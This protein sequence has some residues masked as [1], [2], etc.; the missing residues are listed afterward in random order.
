MRSIVRV[1]ELPKDGQGVETPD[2]ALNLGEHRQ[3]MANNSTKI[4]GE[5]TELLGGRVAAKTARR[6]E[7][8]AANRTQAADVVVDA[9]GTA[10]DL[11]PE[12]RRTFIE[13]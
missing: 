4:G 8:L 6:V 5:S 12:H 9:G 2:L 3:R 1:L 13:G 11:S 10:S 7:G